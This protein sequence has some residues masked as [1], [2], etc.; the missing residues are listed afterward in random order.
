M[1]P[2][3]RVVLILLGGARAGAAARPDRAGRGRR[4][5]GR[6]QRRWR[7]RRW[8]RPR[9]RL[10][11][12]HHHR[13][14]DPH[15]RARPRPRRARA[16]RAGADLVVHDPRH[17]QDH[18][19]V[20]QP[21]RQPRAPV[22]QG[23]QARAPGRAGR[24]RSGRGRSRVRARQGA[25][26]RGDPVQGRA[27]R[28]GRAGRQPAAP[29]GR[30][31]PVPGVAAAAGRLQPQG[32][33]Q[34]RAADRRAGDRVRGAHPHRRIRRPT[35]SWSGS[36][37]GSRT[38]WSTASAAISSAP[39]GWARRR[40]SASTGRCSDPTAA[41]SWPRSRWARRAS[42]RWTTRSSPAPGP[43][44]AACATRRWWRARS[45][46][47]SPTGVKIA[48]VA[49]L[50]YDGDAHSAAMDLS[51]ADGRFAPD[52]LEVAARRAVDAWA[53]AVDGDDTPLRDRHPRLGP[54]AA[55]RRRHERTH[56]PGRPRPADQA[57][58]DRRAGRGL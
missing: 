35:T 44:S 56:P 24:R 6:I 42:T 16:D 4:R 10:R 27:G 57:D 40:G 47:P 34:P 53:Q 39:A 15:R 20:G 55:L 3:R 43:T 26:E 22:R 50:Q 5:L 11:H 33:A 46:T 49:D 18:R 45:P 7:R 9:Q 2:R 17:A 29:D 51:L 36:T 21:R 41:G 58:P 13:P 25:R 14:A 30:A 37:P 1:T 54:R 32:L 12:L 31:R 28:L 48:E 19:V 52:V 8:W 23:L 38:T